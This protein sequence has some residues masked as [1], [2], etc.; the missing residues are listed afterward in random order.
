[1]ANP[2]QAIVYS[3]DLEEAKRVATTL[4]ADGWRAFT[5][6][7]REFSGPDQAEPCNLVVIIGSYL[8][9]E[10]AYRAIADVEIRIADHV[11]GEPVA[12]LPPPAASVDIPEGWE[13]MPWAKIRALALRCGAA[14]NASREDAEAAIRGELSRRGAAVTGV[15]F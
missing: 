8:G 3:G 7:A 12:T 1:M 14:G 13:T 4:R 11:T 15:E 9:V 6:D 5:R 2:R 10:S